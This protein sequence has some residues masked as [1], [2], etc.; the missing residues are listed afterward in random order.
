[1]WPL[2]K[3]KEVS[4]P[5]PTDYSDRYISANT[6]E[7]AFLAPPRTML[8]GAVLNHE[9]I[10]GRGWSWGQSYIKNGVVEYPFY[11]STDELLAMLTRLKCVCYANSKVVPAILIPPPIEVQYICAGNQKLL[12]QVEDFIIAEFPDALTFPY[13]W[14]PE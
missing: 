11:H 14:K 12:R 9:D 6:L 4:P 8:V 13:L 7:R 10:D 3:S 5:P 1:M 2:R